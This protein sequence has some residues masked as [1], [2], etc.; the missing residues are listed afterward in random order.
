MHTTYTLSIFS[1]LLQRK[2][3]RLKWEYEYPNKV[4][5]IGKSLT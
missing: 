3:L 5:I 1:V 2:D 4:K